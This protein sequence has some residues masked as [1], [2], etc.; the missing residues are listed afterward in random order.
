M[1]VPVIMENILAIIFSFY[2]INSLFY[3]G[4]WNNLDWYGLSYFKFLLLFDVY[5][6]NKQINK[7][8]N[9]PKK[10][11]QVMIDKISQPLTGN[12]SYRSAISTSN[13]IKMFWFSY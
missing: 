3:N 5:S 12:V 1:S 7:I 9:R 11:P 13:N 10:N 4:L 8:I 6:V 2:L